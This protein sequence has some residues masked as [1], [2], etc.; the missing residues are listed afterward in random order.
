MTALAA[1][2]PH[3]ALRLTAPKVA[4]PARRVIRRDSRV[5]VW[6]PPTLLES[7]KTPDHRK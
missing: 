2:F 3:L 6:I 1:L 4:A 7:L 5:G